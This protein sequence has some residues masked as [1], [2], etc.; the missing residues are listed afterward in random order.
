[1]Q[2]TEAAFADVSADLKIAE[3]DVECENGQRIRIALYDHDHA[4]CGN[5]RKCSPGAPLIAIGAPAKN[6]ADADHQFL[7][8]LWRAQSE[9]AGRMANFQVHRDQ[10]RDT[11]TVQAGFTDEHLAR[12][13]QLLRARL[14]DVWR[15][16]A[17]NLETMS[18]SF[19][20][21][22]PAHGAN[23]RWHRDGHTAGEF[24]CHYYLDATPST[25]RPPDMATGTD[26]PTVAM[27]WFEVALPATDDADEGAAVDDDE[28]AFALDFGQ[29]DDTLRARISRRNLV[30]FERGA[31]AAEQ[32]L[33]VFEDARA[34]HRT[35]LTAHALPLLQAAGQRPIARI[36]FHGK[37]DDGNELGFPSVDGQRAAGMHAALSGSSARV[38]GELPA[39]LRS[40]VQIH[41][42]GQ[43]LRACDGAGGAA[44]D[45]SNGTAALHP[46][47][48]DSLDA[49]VA[50][51]PSVI[52]S[53]R[54]D[55]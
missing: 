44:H 48:S 25:A 29:N 49:Y 52:S 46:L 9:F 37:G 27:N 53:V 14:F 23:M 7:S 17:P 1:M 16:L 8:H 35:P 51:L 18:G 13:S 33:V 39:G 31:H 30:A 2:T 19:E 43:R 54:G 3:H 26:A 45:A 42:E 50:G 5:S 28:P 34:F 40:A 22:N 24:I 38:C 41:A 36:V 12:L 20:I 21:F 32:R 47:L 55:T 10:S 4:G 6:A 15:A 11:W